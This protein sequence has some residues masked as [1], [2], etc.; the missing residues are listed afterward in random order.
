MADWLAG[1]LADMKNLY[2]GTVCSDTTIFSEH[3]W[4]PWL[5]AIYTIG[6]AIPI[7]CSVCRHSFLLWMTSQKTFMYTKSLASLFASSFFASACMCSANTMNRQNRAA[8]VIVRCSLAAADAFYSNNSAAVH[9]IYAFQSMALNMH[10]FISF[11]EFGE[12]KKT[13]CFAVTA[14]CC[15]DVNTANIFVSMHG[16]S[17]LVIWLSNTSK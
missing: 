13:I 5:C 1:W 4:M 11:I 9:A 2:S 6:N 14:R 15:V 7:V 10:S 17:A 12:E 16:H 8:F 3:I